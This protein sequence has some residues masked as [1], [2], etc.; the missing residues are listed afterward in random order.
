MVLESNTRIRLEKARRLRFPVT[1]NEAKYEA[2]IYS[3]KLAKHV[4]IKRLGVQGDSV[5]VI[6]QVSCKFEVKEPQLKRYY[7]KVM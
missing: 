6:G 7:D 2:S 5:V 1:N 4:G 3:L